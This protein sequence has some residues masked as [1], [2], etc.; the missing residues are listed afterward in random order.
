MIALAFLRPY[1]WQQ[2]RIELQLFAERADMLYLGRGERG[3][4]HHKGEHVPPLHCRHVACRIN[5][6]RRQEGIFFGALIFAVKVTSGLG[7]FFAGWGLEL[8]GFP[9][10]AAPGTVPLETINALA[11]L[12]GPGLSVIAVVAIAILSR[13]RIDRRRHE[14]IVCALLERREAAVA[15]VRGAAAGSGS[16]V[17]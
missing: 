4:F 8:V 11:F 3:A 17:A 5:T 16:A 13:Y 15:P 10:R 12:Y 14:E 2:D 1:T 6:G 9:D 7:Q